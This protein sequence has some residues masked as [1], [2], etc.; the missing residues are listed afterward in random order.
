MSSNLPK[1]FRKPVVIGLAAAIA[2]LAWVPPT[3]AR[4][5]KIIIDR[6]AT[7]TGQDIPYETLTGRAFG[8]LDPLD[9]HNT[10]ITMSRP[11]PLETICRLTTA[12]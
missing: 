1:V 4:V 3:E 6:T 11:R 7:L 8:E 5:T 2:V 10:L 9:S 12:G